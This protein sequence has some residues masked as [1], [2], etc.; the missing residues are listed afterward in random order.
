MS[1]VRGRGAGRGRYSR[2][3]FLRLGGAG[4]AGAAML[5]GGLACSGE[6]EGGGVTEIVFTFGPDD[7]GGLATL[8]EQFNREHEGEIRAVWRQTAAASDEYFDQVRSEL[9][10]GNAAF[11]VIGGDV[12]W[13]AGLAA[14]G[15]LVDLSDRFA[16]RGAFLDGQVRSVEYEGAL[17]G[18]PWFTDAGMFYYRSDLLEEAGFSGPPATWDELREMVRKVRTDLG[19]RYGYVFQGAADESGVVDGLE[20]IWNA[21]GDAIDPENRVVI[22]SPRAR[23]G[24]DLRRSLVADGLAPRASGDYTTQESQAVFTRGDVLF[25]RNWPFVYGLLSDPET[26]QVEPAQVGVSTLPTV[27]AGG[28]SFSG[29][30]GWNFLVN[31]TSEEKIEEAWTFIEFMTAPEQQRTLALQSSR[32]PTR[33]ALY[34]DEEILDAVPIARLGQ[35]ALENARPRPVNP[36]YSDISLALADGFNDHL[37]GNVPTEETLA[38]L[39]ERLENIVEQTS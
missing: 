17:Y 22:D 12:I 26:S 24:L 28:E 4:L 3:E 37:K 32:L 31:A 39:Q 23:A 35:G 5:G 7:G 33:Q 38:T 34:G 20:H 21:G 11:D 25:M 8:V 14:N 29:L 6:A 9:Q 36:Y 16:D 15:W 19:T 30:G 2:R 1:G 10:S 18:V 27:D 13:T